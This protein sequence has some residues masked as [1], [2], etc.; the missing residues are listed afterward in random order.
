[1][2]AMGYSLN[3]LTFL[4][5]VLAIG[6]VV[7]DAIVVSENIY[8][9]IAMGKKP[10][11]AALDGASEIQF[12]VISITL[13]L[14]AV[15]APIGFMTGLT[16]ALFKEFAFTL[17]SEVVVSGFIA[18]TLTPMMCS[19]LLKEDVL[20]GTFPRLVH[21]TS[22]AITNF[23]QKMLCSV[24]R[25]RP[26]ILGFMLVALAGCYFLAALIPGDLAPREDMGWVYTMISAPSSANFEFTDKY[27][28]QIKP[29]IRAVPEMNHYGIFAWGNQGMSFVSLKDWSERKRSVDQVI[30]QDL[31]PKLW[32][33]SGVLAFP[34]NPFHLPGAASF[35]PIEV[36]LQTTGDFAEL[37]E[38]TQKVLAELHK[39]PSLLNIDT[40]LKIDEPQFD[41]TI[42]RNKAADLGISMQDIS[43]AI[44]LAFGEPTTGYFTV[45]GRN[46]D[47]IPQM[48]EN[49]RN[50]PDLIN[51][52]QL[53]TSSGSLVPLSN[54]V[55]I[56]ETIRPRTLN[57]LGE[58]RYAN[59]TADLFPGYSM[60]QAIDFVQ[61]TVKQVAPSHIKIDYGGQTRQY[62][63][64]SGKMVTTFI[65][66]IIF[67]FLVL[68]AQFESFRDPF[69][70]M[71]SVPLSSLGALIFLLFIRGTL[72]IYSEIGL[73]T[74]VGLISK[75]GILMVEFANQLQ[76]QHGKELKEA[77][78]EAATTRLRPILMTTFAMI[79]GALPLAFAHGAGAVSRQ[80]I[81][82]VIVG[83]MSV[84]TLFTLFVVPTMY[85]YLAK[86]RKKE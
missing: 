74:L 4:A 70:V 45:E 52:L 59:I 12:A 31:F 27:V 11:Q 34:M 23:Y 60:G 80:Q 44:N 62:M 48:Q 53:R 49:Y 82:W 18:L 57:H 6:M 81:G 68:A 64:A 22:D 79:L 58:L 25:V 67:I 46:Y 83:G 85:T 43:S 41:I 38:V 77:I 39:N 13:T 63:Q 32:S 75:H 71:F 30:Q 10:L 84:G 19:K 51:S 50:R 8:R 29:I 36:G 17:A 2:L 28:Q 7:D 66:A 26:A 55:S 37:N 86:A 15:Y 65:F 21:K 72:N 78:I 24:L 56:K 35:H 47:V 61:K 76:E 42:N 40:D 16:G 3:T 5:F 9:H 33:I 20:S 69:V 73:V 1:M 14:A 54:V